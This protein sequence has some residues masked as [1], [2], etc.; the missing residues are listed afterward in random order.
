[1]K[2]LKKL[3]NKLQRYLVEIIVKFIPDKFGELLEFKLALKAGK[4]A[5]Y[6]IKDEVERS[7]NLLGYS[8]R[9]FVDIGAHEGNYTREL[10]KIYPQT[11]CHLFEPSKKNNTYLS[12]NSVINTNACKISV[13]RTNDNNKVVILSAIDNLI[14]GGAGQAVQNLNLIYNYPIKEGLR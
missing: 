4:W 6:N 3:S 10:L 12:T 5:N 11:I 1:M 9:V 8:P 2:L 7:L 13:C 14:K